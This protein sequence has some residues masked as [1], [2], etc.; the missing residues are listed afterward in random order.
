MNHRT[1]TFQFIVYELIS[2]QDDCEVQID[3]PTILTGG[4]LP[5]ENTTC[6][7]GV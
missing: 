4:S 2:A 3:W 5:G 7:T 1:W 6:F